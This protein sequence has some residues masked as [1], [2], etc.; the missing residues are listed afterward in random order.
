MFEDMPDLVFAD[1][2]GNIMDF[3]GLAM[4]GRSGDYFLPVAFRETVPLPRGSQLYVLPGR[5][6]VGYDRDT[7][8]IVVLEENPYDG[9][10]PVQ[11]VSTFLP[12]AHTQTYLAAWERLKGAPEL[13]LFPY[14][15]LGWK[16]AFVTTAVR[17]DP[18]LR[19]DPDLF[20][21]DRVRKGVE[22]WR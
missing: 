8:E 1:C 22:Q 9:S 20:D 21:H 10:R 5:Q 18:S 4:V 14:T 17:T 13:P 7:G 19:Q 16:D 3:P 15:A 6:P 11:A 12:A 2:H